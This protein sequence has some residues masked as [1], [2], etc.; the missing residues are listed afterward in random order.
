MTKSAN[1]GAIAP[2]AKSPQ[3][4][5]IQELTELLDSAPETGWSVWTAGDMN[6]IKAALDVCVL[7]AK[8]DAGLD[9][10]GIG[11]DVCVMEIPALAQQLIN[12]VCH[13]N[14]PIADVTHTPEDRDALWLV[15]L[16]LLRLVRQ[17]PTIEHLGRGEHEGDS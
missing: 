17:W 10:D 1:D 13:L 6:K 11:Y 16:S 14:D 15:Q 3:D 5:A 12:R 8:T 4:I 7:P 9:G 2:E